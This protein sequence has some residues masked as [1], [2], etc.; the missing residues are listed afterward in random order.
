MF[1]FIRVKLEKSGNRR[2]V[3]ENQEFM[4]NQ[5]NILVPDNSI[6]Y[7]LYLGGMVQV[8]TG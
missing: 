2:G 6:S 7:L 4:K 8:G 1:I 5:G 3:R